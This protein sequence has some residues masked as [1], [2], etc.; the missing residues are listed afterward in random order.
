MMIEDRHYREFIDFK[1][2][3]KKFTIFFENLNNRCH[4]GGPIKINLL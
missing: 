4:K 3:E 2:I 1:E